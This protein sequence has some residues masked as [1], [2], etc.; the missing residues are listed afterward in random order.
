MQA[1]DELGLEHTCGSEES[2][3]RFSSVINR[4]LRY[5]TDTMDCLQ[6]VIEVDP[7]FATGLIFKCYQLKMASDPRFKT[8]I[9]QTIIELSNLELNDRESRHLAAI[10][11]WFVDD[12]Q[13][14]S[15]ILDELL[16]LYPTDLIALKAAN[17]LH[18][19]RGDAEGMRIATETSL[20]AWPV[21]QSWRSFVEGMLS[22]GYEETGHYREAETLGRAAV[23]ADPMD[24]WA[25]HSVTHAL[26]MQARWN[27]GLSWLDACLPNWVNTNNFTNH[28]HWHKALMLIDSGNAE[29]ALELYDEFL[30][31][32]LKDDFYLD[33]CNASSLLH[34]LEMRGFDMASRW[35]ALAAYQHRI[36]DQELIFIT[37]HYIMIAARLGDKETLTEG[38]KTVKVWAAEP[39]EQGM[40]CET[41]GQDLAVALQALG[42]GDKERA[43]KLL[44]GSFDALP[45]IGGSH[46]QRALFHELAAHC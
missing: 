11:A 36:T 20:N 26:H 43:A 38:L 18:F 31:T 10:Q 13:T 27:E 12:L 28:L 5:A 8:V 45:S 1:T 15:Q 29:A 2:I 16:A 33:V 39:I 21:D 41:V 4:Y 14:V 17:H 44:K 22:F 37:L 35:G 42:E 25:A 6:P 7:R 40:I 30:V 23:A 24:M 32:P 9:Q 34:R 46:A 3:R 19:Y